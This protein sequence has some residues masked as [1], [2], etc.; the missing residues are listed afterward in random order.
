M[1]SSS[2]LG[3]VGARLGHVLR[4]SS[5]QRYGGSD[6]NAPYAHGAMVGSALM[7]ALLMHVVSSYYG[8]V[9][10]CVANAAHKAS[11]SSSSGSGH[12]DLT[13]GYANMHDDGTGSSNSNTSSS[14]SSYPYGNCGA[15][16]P[17]GFVSFLAG[18]LFWLNAVLAG[19]LHVK[20]DELLS[21]SGG[22]DGDSGGGY[23]GSSY[24]NQ[25]DE[26]GIVDV[27]NDGDAGFAGDFPPAS[28][29]GMTTMHV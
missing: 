23:G 10:E 29:T 22:G 5:R 3:I 25:Y 26:I 15:S 16:G 19:T 27:D 4:N 8:G 24:S 2:M 18:L 6:N 21:G 1:S 28:A 11:S 17:V 9:A 12:H 13:G 20:R 14:S 7:M